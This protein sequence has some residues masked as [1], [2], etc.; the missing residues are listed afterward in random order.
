MVALPALVVVDAT[1]T[2]MVS[3]AEMVIPEKSYA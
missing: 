1:E 2:V 3:P